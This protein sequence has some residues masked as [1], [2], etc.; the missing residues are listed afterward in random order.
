MKFMLAGN[1]IPITLYQTVTVTSL[2]QH[3]PTGLDFIKQG[4]MYVGRGHRKLDIG[5]VTMTSKLR[6]N[7]L[8][9]N[10]H[11]D[12]LCFTTEDQD[13]DIKMTCL[14]TFQ[15]DMAEHVGDLEEFYVFLGSLPKLV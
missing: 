4:T 14:G 9:Y 3:L 8:Y 7:A 2:K 12:A 6:K 11:L 13:V 15:E 10:D 1:E 5:G